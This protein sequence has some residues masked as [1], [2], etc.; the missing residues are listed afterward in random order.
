MSGLLKKKVIKQVAMPA[1]YQQDLKLPE[2]P[3]GKTALYCLICGE[4]L[5]LKPWQI[6]F[7][8]SDI[9]AMM[10]KGGKDNRKKL[11]KLLKE[12][13]NLWKTK[14]IQFYKVKFE[15]LPRD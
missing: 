10:A 8:C 13:I 5:K 4:P 2:I 14:Q 9:C 7:Y 15:K 6:V 3:K 11:A 12:D 1:F